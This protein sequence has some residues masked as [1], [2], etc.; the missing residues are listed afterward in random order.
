VSSKSE[1]L[2]RGKE[3][4][5]GEKKVKTMGVVNIS[6]PSTFEDRSFLFSESSQFGEDLRSTK[7]WERHN[8]NVGEIAIARMRGGFGGR[9]ADLKQGGIHD[10]VISV[11]YFRVLRGK[12][13]RF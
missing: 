1:V 5:Q 13:F 11:I 12:T 2:S 8:R 3:N 10:R 7:K 6:K 4:T 9:C